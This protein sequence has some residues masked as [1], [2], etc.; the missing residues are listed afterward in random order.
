MCSWD[1]LRWA[2]K[3]NSL[4]KLSANERKQ[5]QLL[6]RCASLLGVL[7]EELGIDFDELGKSVHRT[8]VG[9]SKFVFMPCR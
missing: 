8:L 1:L 7:W 9:L 6:A 5:K 4:K 3:T 2:K